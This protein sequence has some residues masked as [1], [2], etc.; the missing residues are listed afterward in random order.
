MISVI[1]PVYNAAEFVEEAVRSALSQPEV[2]EVILIE[3]GSSDESLQI[4]QRLASKYETITLLQHPGGKNKGAGASRNLGIQHANNDWIAFLDADDFFL[5][6][7]FKNSLQYIQSH[8]EIDA[9]GEPI[10]AIFHDEKGKRQYID[11]L[12]LSP[13]TNDQDLLTKVTINIPAKNTFETLLLS[14]AGSQSIVGLLVNRRVF[15]KTGPINVDLKIAQDT[16][17]LLKLAYCCNFKCLSDVPPVAIRRIH[18]GNRWNASL[19]KRLYYYSLHIKDLYNFV[20]CKTLS[21]KAAKKI[22]WA[23]VRSHK[24]GYFQTDNKLLK[25]YFASIGYIYLVFSNPR[26]LIKAYL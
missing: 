3:D 22:I 2:S 18:S 24:S 1:I 9:L 5:E 11:H 26:L 13:D 19:K 4:V 15:Q 17:F 6:N 23:Y 25:I 21:K 20:D 12:N 16:N 10:G 7:R 14:N 8:P